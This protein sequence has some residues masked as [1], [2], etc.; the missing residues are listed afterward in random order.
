M[1]WTKLDSAAARTEGWDVFA[2]DGIL[3]IQRIDDPENGEPLF[4][5]DAEALLFVNAQAAEGG[6]LHTKA[7]AV[8]GGR[9]CRTRQDPA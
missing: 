3:Q 4:A 6:S 1:N 5:S 2:A 8:A 9:V 7:M